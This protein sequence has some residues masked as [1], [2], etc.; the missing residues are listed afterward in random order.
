MTTLL[1]DDQLI[2]R[3]LQHID[4]KTTD[5]GSDVWREPSEH[6]SSQER[7]NA[8]LALIKRS[9]VPFCPAAML[10]DKG[11]Y[12][13]RKSAGVPI[14][15]VRGM[16]GEVRGFINGCRHRGMPVAD[17]S[18]CARAFVCP[19][20]AWSYSLDGSLRNIAG[21]HGFPGVDAEQHGLIQV[22]VRE[23]GGLILV[24]QETEI[25]D[26]DLAEIPDFFS[27][28]QEY[29][30]QDSVVDKTNWKLIAETTM[31]GYH[32]KGLHKESFYPYGLDNTN[33]V[34]NFGPHSRVVFPFRRINDL[35]EVEPSKRNLDGLVTTVYNL[36]P[37]TVVSVLSKHSTL[38]VFEP[39]APGQTEILIYRLTNSKSDGS[40][41]SVEE[42]KYDAD[43]VKGAGLDE[44]REA[45]VKIQET[46]EAGRN[47][48]LTFGLFE[49]AIV[50]FH[51]NLEIRLK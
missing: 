50:H 15:V 49:K 24:N 3:I 6:Y 35:R 11:S 28:D 2:D 46:V 39:I 40:T 25:A 9:T 14:L 32:I 16:D 34:E 12:V 43:F 42:A 1:S 51:Q 30:E 13:A 4:N 19:Y 20:H 5:M 33:V 27:Q 23:H 31:E 18:G 41:V 44:D 8:E 10:T 17:G 38:T 48:H 36:F 21:S 29:F 45:A 26:E 7:F 37:N 47:S 22:S